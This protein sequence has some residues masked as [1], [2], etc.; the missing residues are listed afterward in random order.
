M[1]LTFLP[2]KDLR[3]GD[4]F[5]VAGVECEIVR[6]R[7]NKRDGIIIDFYAIEKPGHYPTLIIPVSMKLGITRLN[8]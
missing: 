7:K 1:E 5:T 8:K 3:Q 2:A 6:V 4:L